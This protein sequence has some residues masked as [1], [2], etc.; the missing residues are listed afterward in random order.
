MHVSHILPDIAAKIPVGD[1]VKFQ[2]GFL[3]TLRKETDLVVVGQSIQGFDE[4]GR[5][6]Q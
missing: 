1:S 6:L 4:I 3:S 2:S 5:P